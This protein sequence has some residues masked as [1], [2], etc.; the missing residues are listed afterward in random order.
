MVPFREGK[1]ADSEI[2]SEGV[3]N[4]AEGIGNGVKVN[5]PTRHPFP[6]DRHDGATPNTTSPTSDP[7]LEVEHPNVPP[8]TKPGQGCGRQQSRV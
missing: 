6:L 8:Q 7:T 2:T 4:I 1:I 3:P 5:S